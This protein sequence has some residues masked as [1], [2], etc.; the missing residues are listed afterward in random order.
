MMVEDAHNRT[1]GK[2]KMFSPAASL[3]ACLPVVREIW[4]IPAAGIDR[5]NARE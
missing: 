2:K 4:N 3:S 1:F 5:D